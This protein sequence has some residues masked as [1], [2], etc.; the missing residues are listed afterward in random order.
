MVKLPLTA[1]PLELRTA[2]PPAQTAGVQTGA[3]LGAA[4]IPAGSAPVTT[5]GSTRP[6]TTASITATLLVP[7]TAPPE[8]ARFA[9]IAPVFPLVDTNTPARSNAP[10]WPAAKGIPVVGF[11]LDVVVG[12]PN[13]MVTV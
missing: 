5:L 9:V 3:M 7:R 13:P 8:D 4:L 2:A 12:V 10:A 6:G 1:L 11:A